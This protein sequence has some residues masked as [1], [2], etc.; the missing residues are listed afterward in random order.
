MLP[1]R[2][3]ILGAGLALPLCR[4]L[5]PVARRANKL[6]VLGGTRF[7]GPPVV[8]T[9][10]AAG[11]QVTLFNRG[12]S[13]PELF[14]DLEQIAGDRDAGTLEGLKGRKWDAVV[15]TSAYVPAHVL[16]SCE[17]LRDNVGH[18]V[19]VSTVSVYP[20]QSGETI[21]ET[22][23]TSV[24]K[25]EWLAQASTIREGQAHY[26][27]MKADCERTADKAMPGRVTIVRPGLIVG[28]EDS[29]DRFTY[30]PVRCA[31][32]GEVLAPGEP[33]GEV[34]FVDVRDVG[35]FC[36]AVAAARPAGAFNVVGFKGRLSMAELLH[37]CKVTLNTECSFTWVGE[38]VLL[39]NKV[40]AYTEMPLWLPKGRRG[41]F[42]NQKAVA[43][44]LKFRP[45]AETIR[46]TEAWHRTR[47]ADYE[48]RGGLTEAREK[49]LLAAHRAKAR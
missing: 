17:L 35:A 20:D 43:A 40:R 22:T 34:Q 25:P 6:L 16:Q 44:G 9:A 11:W 7:L 42:A 2:R 48:W 21:D 15:D 19:L 26:G 12:K 38:E 31:R 10:L 30:W 23:A 29:T 37:G 1:T 4:V 5:P 24:P 33:D 27:P 28:P 8:R 46:D 47:P 36:F 39:A 3:S 14:K 18:Y 32:G 45:V 41:H 13:N 49:E